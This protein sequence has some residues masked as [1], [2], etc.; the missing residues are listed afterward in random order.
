MEIRTL[1]VFL[2]VSG[3]LLYL[4]G[5]KPIMLD[6][7]SGNYSSSQLRDQMIGSI[8]AVL[9]GVGVATVISSLFTPAS[10]LIHYIAP[11]GLLLFLFNT[12]LYPFS[13]L[14]ELGMPPVLQVF[15]TGF[16]NLML[17]MGAVQFVR[18]SVL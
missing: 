1:L 13:F 18:G 15:I 5:Y 9:G 4:A 8:L 16:L 14:Y 10:Q 2:F 17:L 3:F 11:L 12:V 6:L 7:L